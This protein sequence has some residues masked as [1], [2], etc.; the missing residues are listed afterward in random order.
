MGSLPL[1]PLTCQVMVREF[2]VELLLWGNYKL[3]AE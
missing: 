1:R 3:E 2:V